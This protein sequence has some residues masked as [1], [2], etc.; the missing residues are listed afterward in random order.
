MEG[1]ELV[2]TR[3]TVTVAEFAEFASLTTIW[4]VYVPGANPAGFALN[5][6]G[7]GVEIVAE[8]DPAPLRVSQLP[9]LVAW[10]VNCRVPPPLLEMVICP[11]MAASPCV[12]LKFSAAGDTES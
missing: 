11:L 5:P 3:T 8:P 1:E 2:I 12:A 4:P 10:A 6:T 7:T 9:W